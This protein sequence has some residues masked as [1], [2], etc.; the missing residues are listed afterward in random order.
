LLGD[1]LLSAAIVNDS[2]VIA[3]DN[4]RISFRLRDRRLVCPVCGALNEMAATVCYGCDGTRLI[5]PV[6]SLQLRREVTFRIERD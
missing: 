4:V 2:L 6:K 5:D 1:K 3:I